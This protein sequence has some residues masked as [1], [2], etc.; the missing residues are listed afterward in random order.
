[1]GALLATLCLQNAMSAWAKLQGAKTVEV[2]A[3]IDR[4]L[5]SALQFIRSERGD[6]AATL[7][8][9]GDQA[10]KMLAVIAD[11]RA[12][13]DG[14]INPALDALAQI[15]APGLEARLADLK[16]AHDEQLT[17]RPVL[18][19]AYSQAADARDKALGPKA[20]QTGD[21]MVAALE[22]TAG[23]LEAEMRR[24]DPEARGLINVKNFAWGARAT[25]GALAVAVNTALSKNRAFTPEDME[26]VQVNHGRVG[27]LWKLVRESVGQPGTPKDIV[28]AVEA[29]QKDYFAPEFTTRVKTLEHALATGA[30]PQITLPEWQALITPS[31]I[32]IL[33]VAIS[34]MDITVQNAAVKAASARLNLALNAAV[35][36]V[37]VSLVV[38][39]FFLAR[40]K[41]ARPIVAMTATMRELAEGNLDVDLPRH[42]RSDEIGAMAKAVAVFKDNAVAMRQLQAEAAKVHDANA[43]KLRQLEAEYVETGRAQSEVVE[44]MA[45]GLAQLASGDLTYRI[46]SHFAAEY[47]KLKEDFNA[48]MDRL[49][50]TMTVILENAGGI[51]SD[52]GEL[53]QATNDLSRR[54]EQQAASLEETA[55]AL[56]E[57]TAAVR[58]TAGGARAVKDVASV[59]RTDADH[60]GAIVR[61]AIRAME[62]IVKSSHEITR[63]VGVIDEIAFQTNLLAL[64]AGVEAARAGDS[65]RGFAVVAAEV[66]ALAQRSAEA[67]KE[68]RGLILAS[69]S[70]VDHGVDLV[71]KSGAILERIA[72]EIVEIDSAVNQIA[73]A[74]DEQATGLTEVNAAITQMDQVTQQNAAMVEQSTA[75]SLSVAHEA[76]QLVELMA[77]FRIGKIAAARASSPSKVAV[78][79]RRPQA[80]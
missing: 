80:A 16:T 24:L 25:G 33:N 74:A 62:G 51:E 30:D 31:L 60:S 77:R 18:D 15:D 79:N 45:S 37:T 21:K 65:G 10:V 19:Q 43:V 6:S 47:L 32:K 76:R 34:A 56:N 9:A 4:Q 3:G 69:K 35:L 78:D 7:N 13:L 52:T 8:V 36:L 50:E 73:A 17:L 49:H 1:M 46:E 22:G 38:G 40:Y 67:A 41:I 23:F 64:N 28:D 11:D 61:D 29:A 72:Q 42:D 71:G 70:E 27:A 5:L 63:I 26:A 44:A 12:K 68:I 66:R 58:T 59:A 54:T 75:A 55:A 2:L 57:I 39:G 20:L 48:A 53:S 14:A